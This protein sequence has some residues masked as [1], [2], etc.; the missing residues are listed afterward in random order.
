MAHGAREVRLLGLRKLQEA[1]RLC[2]VW[3]LQLSVKEKTPGLAQLECCN[4]G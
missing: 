1:G 3:G 2:R 4:S